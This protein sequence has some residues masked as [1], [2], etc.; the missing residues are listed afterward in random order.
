MAVVHRDLLK[1]PVQSAA[2]L[3]CPCV[4]PASWISLLRVTE[5]FGIGHLPMVEDSSSWI[6]GC[7]GIWMYK[8]VAG[9]GWPGLN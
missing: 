6:C 1:T 4:F 8:D 3:E 9:A 2:R 7:Q 5:V